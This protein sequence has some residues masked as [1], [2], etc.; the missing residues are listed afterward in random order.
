MAR[1]SRK[2][3]DGGRSQRSCCFCPI[4]SVISRRK[5]GARA[6][7][8]GP[9]APVAGGKVRSMNSLLRA[10]WLAGA[11]A[12]PRLIQVR[13]GKLFDAREGKLRAEMTIPIRG[14]R[15]AS[16]APTADAPPAAGAEVIDLS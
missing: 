16:V 1:L 8:S 3:S 5:V 13:A 11:A 12:A 10:A 14:D 7:G 9:P 6:R 2:V 15:I 4:T